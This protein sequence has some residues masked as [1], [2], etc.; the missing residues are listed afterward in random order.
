MTKKKGLSIG[1]SMRGRMTS[2]RTEVPEEGSEPGEQ[3]APVEGGGGAR[4]T[5]MP[6]AALTS[7]SSRATS[8]PLESFN[9]RLR[10]S[11]HRRLKV[12][13]AVHNVKIQDVVNEALAAY[14][15]SKEG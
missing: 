7:T 12:Y 1:E 4:A 13:S 10:Q 14:L 8:D 2:M 6:Q 3:N 15:A 5:P 9:T 11:T